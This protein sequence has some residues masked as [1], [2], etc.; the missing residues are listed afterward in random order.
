[1]S[2][3]A[4]ITS[5]E[6]RKCLLNRCMSKAT[7]AINAASAA[8]I[9]TTGATIYSVNGV[10][11]SKAALSAQSIVPTHDA[12]GRPVAEGFPA[13]VQPVN[14]VAY[15]LVSVNAGGTVAISQGNYDGQLQTKNLEV[16]T[17]NGA[18]P[19]EPAGYTTIGVFKVAPTVA[20]T[21][22]PGTTAL[23]AANVAVTY[24]DVAILPDSL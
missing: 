5:A 1:M 18:I 2:S 9:K 7:L 17:G 8:T 4:N 12:L 11:Y 16:F 6:V 3:I 15:Y 24:Y 13:Y 23:D 14:T 10:L 20:A 21:F 19:V 22:T